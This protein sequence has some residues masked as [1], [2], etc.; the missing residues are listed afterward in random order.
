MSGRL[1]GSLSSH[2]GGGLAHNRRGLLARGHIGG[3]SL[4]NGGR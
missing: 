3:L 4:L 2:S 1:E